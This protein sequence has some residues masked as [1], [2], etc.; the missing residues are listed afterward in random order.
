M[1][2]LFHLVNGPQPCTCLYC[3]LRVS[4]EFPLSFEN[5]LIVYDK[6]T[7]PCTLSAVSFRNSVAAHYGQGKD[8]MADAYEVL[9]FILFVYDL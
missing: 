3:S 7:A 8:E 9:V 5:F 6:Q 2:S 4:D 1:G